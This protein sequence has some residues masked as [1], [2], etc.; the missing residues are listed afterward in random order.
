MAGNKIGGLKASKTNRERYGEDYYKEMG[1]KGG[2]N[3]HK[4]GF[5]SNPELARMAGAKGGRNSTRGESLQKK[6]DEVFSEYIEKQFNEGRS[7]HYI[8]QRIGVSD[9][10]IK[11]YGVRHNLLGGDYTPIKSY[12]QNYKNLQN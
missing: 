7:I 4:G 2:M 8:A 6:L 3:G 1:R 9:Q 5:A 10:T 11:R 12:W